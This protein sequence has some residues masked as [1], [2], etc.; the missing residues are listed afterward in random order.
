MLMYMGGMQMTPR[1]RYTPSRMLEPPGTSLMPLVESTGF[2]G[3]VSLSNK[4]NRP[5]PAPTDLSTSVPTRKPRRMALF[6]P[7]V[8]P[9]T[10]WCRRI[11]FGG[12]HGACRQRRAQ[13]AEHY[14]RNIAV[15][16]LTLGHERLYLLLQ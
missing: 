11:G 6:H 8:D 3:N 5:A 10:G 2:N 15:S 7:C 9:P 1:P 13:T 16:G 12:A 14:A 4:G